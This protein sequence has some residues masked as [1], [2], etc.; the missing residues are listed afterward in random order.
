MLGL[1]AACEADPEMMVPMGGAEPPA[2]LKDLCIS[3]LNALVDLEMPCHQWSPYPNVDP[4]AISALARGAKLFASD[5]QSA[6]WREV[7]GNVADAWMNAKVDPKERKDP[8][9]HFGYRNSP[10][11]M[12]FTYMNKEG[13]VQQFYYLTGHWIQAFSDL[14]AATGDKRYRERAEAMISYLCGDNPFHVRLLNEIGG[15]YNWT[16]DTDGDG[17]EDK[18]KQDMYPEASA[19][20]QIGILS[21]VKT[22]K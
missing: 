7:A 10:G 21:L 18:L 17:I 20:T 13:R 6:R 1:L 3:S 4:M 2:K 19:F 12:T 11:T 5:S 8:S 16:D 14:Y 22:L 9:V 15:V